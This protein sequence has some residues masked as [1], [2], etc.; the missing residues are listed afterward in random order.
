MPYSNSYINI[1]NMFW[2]GGG[3]KL[4]RPGIEHSLKRALNDY[5]ARTQ[6]NDGKAESATVTNMFNALSPTFV[7]KLLDYFSDPVKTQAVYDEWHNGMCNE[8]IN[9][10]KATLRR[11]EPYGKAQKIVN[12]TMKTIYCLEGAETKAENGYFKHCHMPLD[13]ITLEW[14]RKKLAGDWYNPMKKQA[15]KI[16]LTIDKNAPMPSWSALSFESESLS[17]EY[18][19]YDINIRTRVDSREKYHYMFFVTMIRE[20]FKPGNSKNTYAGLTPFQ[21]E[22][23]IWPEQQWERSANAIKDQQLLGKLSNNPGVSVYNPQI[24]EL[25]EKLITDLKGMRGFYK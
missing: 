2:D 5:M 9:K 23:F 13:S 15:E 1:R 24:K 11:S 21:A 25:Y 10:M 12:M 16:K 22:F 8:F 7:D 18:T 3:F 4:D 19:N 20:Y 14:F 6:S 17:Y